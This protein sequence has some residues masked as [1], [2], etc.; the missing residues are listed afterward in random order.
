[1]SNELT[2]NRPTDNARATQNE[3]NALL[4]KTW[5]LLDCPPLKRQ[6][7]L[8]VTYTLFET[9]RFAALCTRSAPSA[10]A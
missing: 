10:A 8:L 2:T 1:M 3:V 7:F 9:N 5:Q 6:Q 4:L